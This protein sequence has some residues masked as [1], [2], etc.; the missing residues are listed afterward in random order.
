M[1]KTLILIIIFLLLVVLIYM[2]LKTTTIG[3]LTIYGI[4]GL[5]QENKNLDNKIQTASQLTGVDY[6]NA[7]TDL[8]A[9][10]KQYQTAKQNY[11]ELVALSTA[12][13]VT[14]ASQL[15][16]YEIEY[17]WAQIGKHATD[18][19]VVLK[20]EISKNDTSEA[21][22]YYDLK[23]VAT[24]S[25]VGLTDFI[26]DIENDS[27][28]AFKIENFKMIPSGGENELQATFTCKDISINIDPAMLDSGTDSEEETEGTEEET[29]SNE[30][31][32]EEDTTEDTN[33]TD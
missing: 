19:N 32:T 13:D 21:T 1:R 8:T 17:L 28:W 23:F 7:L 16:K 25:Y 26:Y 15:E 6:Q 2:S 18:E 10:A 29:S 4:N 5:N 30:E 27:S 11:E 12:D 14:A 24:G 33:T 3:S 22:G 20:L 31:T 9:S